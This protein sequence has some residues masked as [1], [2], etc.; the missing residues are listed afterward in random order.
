MSQIAPDV[1]SCGSLDD[2]RSAKLY[3]SADDSSS[4]ASP[5]IARRLLRDG[6]LVPAQVLRAHEF[7]NYYDTGF[8]PAKSGQVAMTAQL[9]SCPDDG[10]LSLQ[11]ALRAEARDA[12][13]RPPLTLTFVLDT[14]G[15]MAGE[16]IDME[17]EAVRVMAGQL[18]RGDIVS[19]VTWSSDQ[20]DILAGYEVT[21]PDDQQLLNAVSALEANGGTDLHAG[22]VRG[23]E[24]AQ[25]SFAAKRINRVVLISDGGANL[26]ITDEE[27]IGR[28]ADDEEGQEGIYLA[29]IGVGR[30]VN[31]T[32][33]DAVTDVGRGAYIY[34]DS[35]AEA[36][37]MLG[38]H[39][40]QVVDVAA[41]AVR[42]EVQLPWYLT[43]E[44]FYGEV[45]STEASKVR[46]QHLSPNDQM[47]FFQT[48]RA[49]D[50]AQLHG[51]DRIRLRATWETPFTRAARETVIDTTLNA[52][53]GNDA[54]LRRAAAVAGYADAL[55]VAAAAPQ[56]DSAR[57]AAETALAA[58]RAAND[59]GQDLALNEIESLLKVLLRLLSNSGAA[60][61]E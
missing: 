1:P 19:M 33:M 10:M 41:R 37:R 61:E 57:E 2:K 34:L 22:L 50:V 8:A 26:G 45:V 51:D 31:D 39:F 6:R 54:V 47:L 32:L 7:L 48:L 27:L 5:V 13:D 18:R 43:I 49:C 56:S 28:F 25:K 29:G 53:A 9:S 14:S 58:T 15:S 44:K 21:G 20:K 59:N 42:L 38:E 46:P 4:L 35:E 16:P 23:Y 12:D 60:W 11:V 3:M 24:L 55:A 52:L 36:Q 30:D 17:R 40:L